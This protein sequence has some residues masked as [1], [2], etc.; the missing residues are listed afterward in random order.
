MTPTNADFT[1]KTL[2]KCTIDSPLDIQ[3]FID[4][5]DR[6]LYDTHLNTLRASCN[7]NNDP[8]TFELAG[9]RRKIYFDPSKTKAAI[10]SCGG[11][12][13]GI[14]NIIRGIVNLLWFQYGVHNII[15]FKY[16]YQGIVPQYKHPIVE[17]TPDYVRDIHER[18]GSILSSSRGPQPT[19][20]IVD[21]L[22][23]MNIDILFTIGGDGTQRGSLAIFEEAS[24]RNLK[25]AAVGIPK[26]IDNDLAYIEKTFGFET[27]F[28]AAVD[29]IRCAHEE[30]EGAPNGIGIVK[31]MG[32][33]SGFIAARATLATNE[34]NFCLIPEVPFTLQGLTT[35]IKQRLAT[36]RHAVIVVAE[37]AG[38]DIIPSTD[39]TTDASGNKT[40]MDIGTYLRDNI[41]KSL[42]IDGIDPNIKYIDPSYIIRSVP[43]NPSDSVYC[44]QL[45]QNA[46]HAALAGKTGMVVARWNGQ[47]TNVPVEMVVSKRNYV[48]P[49]STLWLNVLQATGQPPQMT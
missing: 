21:A 41:K 14:N 44:I 38:Q 11:L 29:V 48:D 25:L 45:A 49:H 10:V 46:V 37:G 20:T 17:L 36:R 33:Y 2:G 4:D 12:C 5:D 1:V 23:R 34:V 30:A 6:I 28:G 18:G 27:A 22:E 47:F 42:K 24:R 31:L 39:T 8:L 40:L 7:G 9:P 26:T 19:E 43:A 3:Y 15:G 13:P 16:G 35:A 32:R